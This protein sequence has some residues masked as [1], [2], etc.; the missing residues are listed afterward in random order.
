M[1][2][3]LHCFA[4]LSI[5]AVVLMKAHSETGSNNKD[6][7]GRWSKR[8]DCATHVGLCP[9]YKWWSGRSGPIIGNAMQFCWIP[10]YRAETEAESLRGCRPALTFQDASPTGNANFQ[11]L[12]T[13]QH[14][15]VLPQTNGWGV[16][17]A[18][19]AEAFPD[20]FC[21]SITSCREKIYNPIFLRSEAKRFRE[22][23]EGAD[24]LLCP[25]DY[26]YVIQRAREST[27]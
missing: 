16:P 19:D 5:L 25:L 27:A 3:S 12:L 10:L 8:F 23:L 11:Y 13:R 1:M 2:S 24:L 15:N 22:L 20:M 18:G 9:W 14:S 6:W 21:F 26:C 7:A 4:L 17:W